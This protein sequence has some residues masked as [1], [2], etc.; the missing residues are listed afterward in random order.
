MSS[1]T[2]LLTNESKRLSLRKQTKSIVC[3]RDRFY[4]GSST[5]TKDYNLTYRQ[6]T[7]VKSKT[8][9]LSTLSFSSLKHIKR[10]QTGE[11]IRREDALL[12][13]IQP[14]SLCGR[15][16][17]QIHFMYYGIAYCT[18]FSVTRMHELQRLQ[19]SSF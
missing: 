17:T 16:F 3:M 10:L 14:I 15:G 7:C 19:C 13:S 5:S 1:A 6:M 9:T 12:K 11:K 4:R 18:S 8:R 2:P